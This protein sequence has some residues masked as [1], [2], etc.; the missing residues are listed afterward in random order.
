MKVQFK[1]VKSETYEVEIDP[2]STILQTKYALA[3]QLGTGIESLKLIFG[4]KILKDEE[5]LDSCQVNEKTPIVFMN[6]SLPKPK[7][8]PAPEPAPP[9]DTTPIPGAVLE[10]HIEPVEEPVVNP[11]PTTAPTNLGPLPFGTQAFQI[12]APSPNPNI[13]MPPGQGGLGGAGSTGNMG[14]M[15][16]LI[17]Q[18]IQSGQLDLDPVLDSMMQDPQISQLVG[19]DKEQLREIM[20]DPQT[21]QMLGAMG[22]MG[23]MGGTGMSGM[24][25]PET[26]NFTEEENQQID[27][28]VAMFGD[29]QMV[30]QYYIAADK[31]KELAANMLMNEQFDD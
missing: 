24:G 14:N 16:G 10:P 20:S 1:N 4:G 30:V 22:G 25:M 26:L 18:M 9:I 21:L 2:S 5:T 7:S 3:E 28:L 19:G 17:T 23:G 13:I 8:K 29:E 11:P 6:K 15:G 27:E 12:P 31:N